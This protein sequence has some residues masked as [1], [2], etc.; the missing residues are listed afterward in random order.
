MSSFD[1]TLT[2]SKISSI[3]SIDNFPLIS[4][5]TK[6]LVENERISKLQKPKIIDLSSI[7][8]SDEMKVLIFYLWILAQKMSLH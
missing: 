7:L 4:Q 5:K 6:I 3:K 8:S 1:K 2:N